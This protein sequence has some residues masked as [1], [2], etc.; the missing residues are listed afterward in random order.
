MHK[1]SKI[2]Y[3]TLTV[4]MFIPGFAGAAVELFTSGPESIVKIMIALGYPLYLMKILGF[5]KLLGSVAILWGRFPKLKE[6]AYAG[7]AFDYLGATASHVL[8]ADAPAAVFPFLFLI[9]MMITYYLWY[10][11]KATALPSAY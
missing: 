8:A 2:I 1:R 9:V 11:T 10:K 5:A 3:W 7:F 4:L 6:W